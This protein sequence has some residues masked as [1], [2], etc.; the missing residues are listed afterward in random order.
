MT[1][2]EPSWETLIVAVVSAAV[3]WLMR[4]FGMWNT[5]SGGD[6]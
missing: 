5:P 2:P 1:V 4:W 3:G 6:K